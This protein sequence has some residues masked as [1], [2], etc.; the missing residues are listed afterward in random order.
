M[1]PVG[2]RTSAQIV[3]NWYNVLMIYVLTGTN[4]YEIRL[5]QAEIIK[6]LKSQTKQP[7]IDK[8]TL[9][10]LS[11]LLLGEN[12]FSETVTIILNGLS[13]RKDIYE[14]A[15]NLI[16][17]NKDKTDIILIENSLDKRT[18]IYK[19]LAKNAKIENYKEYTERDSSFLEKWILNY[20]KEKNI[21]MPVKAVR[22]LINWVG[23]NQEQLAHAVNRL[24]LMNDFT[25]EGIKTYIPKTPSSF[26]FDLLAT[27][28]NKDSTK[29]NEMLVDLKQTQEPHMLF[30]L[31]ASQLIQATTLTAATVNENVAKDLGASPYAISNLKRAINITPK[32]AKQAITIL[33]E[34]DSSMKMSGIDPWQAIEIALKKLTQL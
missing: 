26:A 21:T 2:E 20:A 24:A 30:G 1:W 3:S 15:V 11:V 8:L 10:E 14:S 16:I 25:E 23:P 17:K 9:S 7:N 27:A 28:I 12:L 13:E 5:R 29:L 19:N 4:L 18:I 34:A 33:Y 6:S 32:Q 22:L 31:L